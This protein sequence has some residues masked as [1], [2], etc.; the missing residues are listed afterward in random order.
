MQK[1]HKKKLS[2]ELNLSR[3]KR[4]E[5]LKATKIKKKESR[6]LRSLLLFHYMLFKKTGFLNQIIETGFLKYL[7]SFFAMFINEF[8]KDGRKISLLQNSI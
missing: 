1:K 7:D 5:N 2:F 3:F 4:S 6:F 8:F